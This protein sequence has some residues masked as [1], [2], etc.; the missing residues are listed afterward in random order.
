MRKVKWMFFG[1]LAFGVLM[2]VGIAAALK[3]SPA[4]DPDTFYLPTAGAIKT[5][6]P[7]EIG[8]TVGDGIC[9]YMCEG[10]YNYKYQVQPYTLFPE[11]AAEMPNISADGLTM[12][13][14]VR[15]GIHYY[16]AGK[17]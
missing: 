6:D 9:K 1:Y 8:D 5:L 17:D 3:S 10:L 2:I 16:D 11:L 4:R 14:P 13:I 15:H 12:T 7:A